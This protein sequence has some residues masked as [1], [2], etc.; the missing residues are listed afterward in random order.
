VYRLSHQ[1]LEDLESIA[2]YLGSRDLESANRVLDTLEKTFEL[3]N[4]NPEMGVL[5]ED[6]HVGV[7]LFVPASPAANYAIFYYSAPDGIEISDVLH[8]A[9]DWV[10]IFI[11]GE[12]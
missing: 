7:R 2:D 1:A 8:A 5:R 9:R 10:G 4:S 12:R 6:L 3:L 11:R